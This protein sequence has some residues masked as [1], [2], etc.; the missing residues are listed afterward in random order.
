M[1]INLFL[2]SYYFSINKTLHVIGL[3]RYRD[4]VMI[5]NLYLNVFDNRK[6]DSLLRND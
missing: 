3:C 5:K 2:S 1:Y 4:V 6:C